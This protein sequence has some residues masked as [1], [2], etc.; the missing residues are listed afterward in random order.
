[1]NLDLEKLKISQDFSVDLGVHRELTRVSIKKP[2]KQWFIRVHPDPS[3]RLSVAV[4][5][6]KED[7]ETY[8][9]TPE[10][11]NELIT[12]IVPKV[13]LYAITMQGQAFIWPIRMPGPD[14]KIDTW[15]SSALEVSLIAQEKWC[16]IVSNMHLGAYEAMVASRNTTEPKWPEK[17]F[18]QI[19]DL[20]FKDRIIDSM[21]HLVLRRLRG[22]V[23]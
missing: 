18:Q 11:H 10:L 13:L 16:R 3:F 8:I 21:D 2:D 12:E 19:M 22:E 23:L 1:M 17:S 20:A 14:G 9:V 6:L 15:N 7:R 5:E 4:I